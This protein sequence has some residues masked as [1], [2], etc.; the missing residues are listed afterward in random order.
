VVNVELD[1]FSGRPNPH[2]VLDT[3][4][5]DQF[6]A[7]LD[8]LAPTEAAPATQPG[9]GYRGFRGTDAGTHWHAF[10]GTVVLG[11]VALAD[12]QRLVEHWLLGQ[13]PDQFAQLRDIVAAELDTRI[14]PE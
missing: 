14:E 5:V 1:P 8:L 13:L 11:G 12:P 3:G 6:H 2:W 7:I 4:A 9:L 10:G